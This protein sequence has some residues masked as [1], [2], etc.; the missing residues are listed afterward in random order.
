MALI[1]NFPT[2]EFYLNPAHAERFYY[3]S[4]LVEN[5]TSEI[6][7]ISGEPIITNYISFRIRRKVGG[8]YLNTY[9]SRLEYEGKEKILENIKKDSPK[10]F[11]D[12]KL[13]GNR[14]YS[15]LPKFQKFLRGYRLIEE[16][17]GF[18][19]YEI[20]LKK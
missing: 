10:I 1:L 14:Y 18:P 15:S 20:Y 16:V 19:V 4:S 7:K 2:I 5:Q 12:M 13:K 17:E 8:G 11:I 3:I 6:D 9:L